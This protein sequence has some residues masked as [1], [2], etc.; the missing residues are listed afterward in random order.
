MT[1]TSRNA[2]KVFHLVEHPKKEEKISTQRKGGGRLNA[3]QWKI[4]QI[5]F[6]FLNLPF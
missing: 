5:W 4:S 2:K 6:F 1:E 3:L